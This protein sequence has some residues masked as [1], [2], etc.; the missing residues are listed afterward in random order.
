MSANINIGKLI[1]QVRKNSHMTK[2]HSLKRVIYRSTLFRGLNGQII[3]IL[4]GK[5]LKRFQVRWDYR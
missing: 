3:K 1:K 2:K 5:I 4:A